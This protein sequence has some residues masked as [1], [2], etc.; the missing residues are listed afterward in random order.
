MWVS[1]RKSER[2]R[3]TP[4]T[5]WSDDRC[6]ALALSMSWSSWSQGA[7]TTLLVSWLDW[8][9]GSEVRSMTRTLVSWSTVFTRSTKITWWADT[10]LN[11]K[12]KTIW[13]ITVYCNFPG[14]ISK[15]SRALMSDMSGSDQESVQ[16]SQNH[17]E[18]LTGGGSSVKLLIV[19]LI[20]L[21]SDSNR[22]V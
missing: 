13:G 22:G 8:D 20:S 14:D 4:V 5:V 18:I 15:A 17:E 7:R 12:C 11:F 1:W 2:V 16:I 21:H 9:T 6:L 10:L 19:S 3:S